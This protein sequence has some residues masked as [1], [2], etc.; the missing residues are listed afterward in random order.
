MAKSVEIVVEIDSAGR[1]RVDV[2]G[3]KGRACLEYRDAIARVLG[4]IE[5]EQTTAELHETDEV[6]AVAEAR[7]RRGGPA[8]G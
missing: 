8:K 5:S 4:R 6:K 2:S 1:V 3:A 7:V